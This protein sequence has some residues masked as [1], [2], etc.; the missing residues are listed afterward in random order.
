M[1]QRSK[2]FP[3]YAG[4]LLTALMLIASSCARKLQFTRSVVV[5]A[6]EGRVKVKKDNNKNY[7]LDIDIENL[8]K[9]EDL[10]PAKKTYVVWI[11]SE[12][13]SSRNVGQLK[14]SSGLFSSKLKASLNTVTAFEPKRVFI[15]AEDEADITYPYGQ[16]ILT[17][18]RF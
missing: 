12:D 17:T 6:A 3:R 15:T 1:K 11:E 18:E 4:L 9:V 5:P 8:A 14:S 16:T 10:Q 13:S 2:S 7:S